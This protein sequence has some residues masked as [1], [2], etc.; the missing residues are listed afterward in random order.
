MAQVGPVE[1]IPAVLRRVEQRRREHTSG[2]VDEDA[3]RAE[4]V[5]GLGE[6]GVDLGALADV[7]RDAE[8]ADR[9]GGGRAGV[10]V[11]FPD[12]DRRTEGGEA[13]GDATADAGTAAGHD[14]HASGQQ[15]GRRI[16]G[17]AATLGPPSSPMC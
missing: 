13:G 7:G 4:L 6:R 2:V 14:G 8:R 10:R 16:E 11:T 12:R 9:I 17:H 15:D 5:D 3:D 1:R